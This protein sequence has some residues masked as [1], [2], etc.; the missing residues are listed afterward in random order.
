MKA[1]IW[2]DTGTRSYK[3]NYFDA[4]AELTENRIIVPLRNGTEKLLDQPTYL[5]ERML[6]FAIL[7]EEIDNEE[8]VVGALYFANRLFKCLKQKPTEEIVIF[9]SSE[10]HVIGG[11]PGKCYRG[12][13]WSFDPSLISLCCSGAVAIPTFAPSVGDGPDAYAFSLWIEEHGWYTDFTNYG[14]IT[15][16][17]R[18]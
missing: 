3:F 7:R 16:M 12:K 13:M 2:T 14:T 9:I 18:P 4:G 15:W 5:F 1:R 17:A 11:L 6:D 10:A 8:E